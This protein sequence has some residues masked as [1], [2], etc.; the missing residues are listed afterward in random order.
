M[1]TTFNAAS[2]RDGLKAVPYVLVNLKAVLLV[3]DG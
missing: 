2:R 3:G 1:M